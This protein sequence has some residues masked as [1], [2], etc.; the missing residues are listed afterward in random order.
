MLPRYIHHLR[1]AA[2]MLLLITMAA[3][4][5]D[6]RETNPSKPGNRGRTAPTAVVPVL[7]IRG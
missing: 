5:Q 1:Y 6:E 4:R 7:G 3:N 2:L